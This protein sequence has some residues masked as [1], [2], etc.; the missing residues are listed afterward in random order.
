MICPTEADSITL[1]FVA[2]TLCDIY[3]S[4][5]ERRHEL[6][7]RNYT[8]LLAMIYRIRLKLYCSV[9]IYIYIYIYRE[10]ERE[11][12]GQGERERRGW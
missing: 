10:R 5:S 4:I 11:R 7:H 3:V 1:L 6:L 8:T 2:V 9:Y 12:E